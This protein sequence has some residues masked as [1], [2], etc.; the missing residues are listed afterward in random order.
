M[1]SVPC[2]FRVA[3]CFLV[4]SSANQGIGAGKIARA[5][6]CVRERNLCASARKGWEREREREKEGERRVE[7][8]LAAGT[9]T[10]GKSNSML[11]RCVQDVLPPLLLYVVY[12]LKGLSSECMG[13]WV[14]QLMYLNMVFDRKARPS[15]E[16]FTQMSAELDYPVVC[17]SSCFSSCGVVFRPHPPT[18]SFFFGLP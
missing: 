6:V 10:M 9:S 16:D 14:A 5:R 1:V 7:L 11:K 18:F 8:C 4:Q 15:R 13:G 2:L 17:R 3:S 12:A